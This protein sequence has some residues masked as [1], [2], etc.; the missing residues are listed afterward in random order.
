M[1]IKIKKMIAQQ[2]GAET[3]HR[4]AESPPVS[5]DEVH[6]LVLVPLENKDFHGV[7]VGEEDFVR[8]GPWLV[9]LDV[10]GQ[11]LKV[12]FE[13]LQVLGGAAL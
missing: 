12:G 1:T 4:K 7:L 9:V 2:S 6:L 5:L 11:G 3:G 10:L 13:L 8:E